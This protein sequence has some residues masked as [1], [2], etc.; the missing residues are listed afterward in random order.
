MVIHR[1]HVL[2]M[3]MI[4]EDERDTYLHYYD[5]T[6]FLND[7]PANQQQSSSTHDNEQPFEYST[8]RIADLSRYMT[9]R[10]QLRN[11]EAHMEL[12]KDLIDLIWLK[13]GNHE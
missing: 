1:V 3:K 4:V 12:Q 8:E 11:R 6:E 9:N 5:P 10:A 7:I 2:H 13:F